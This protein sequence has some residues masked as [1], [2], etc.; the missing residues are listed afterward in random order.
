MGC[1]KTYTNTTSHLSL[2]LEEWSDKVWAEPPPPLSIAD[3]RCVAWVGTRS[4]ECSICVLSAV[5]FVH[6]LLGWAPALPSSKPEQAELCF[7]CLHWTWASMSSKRR[8]K[9]A[10]ETFNEAISR[11]FLKFSSQFLNMAPHWLIIEKVLMLRQFIIATMSLPAASVWLCKPHMVRETEG[12]P[13]QATLS[14]NKTLVP[15]E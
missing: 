15:G 7:C 3:W 8:R 5:P 14:L 2:L 6:M 13:V 1:W 4:T 12:A 11:I 9:T 10:T